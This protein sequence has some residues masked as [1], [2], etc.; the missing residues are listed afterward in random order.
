MPRR[1]GENRMWRADGFPH[2]VFDLGQAVCEVPGE[3]RI[4][5]LQW[6]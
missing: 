5:E 6:Q 2:P 1:G 3:V 4:G